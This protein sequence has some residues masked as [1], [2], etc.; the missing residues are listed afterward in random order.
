MIPPDRVPILRSSSR[1]STSIQ[2][3]VFLALALPLVVGCEANSTDPGRSGQDPSLAAQEAG[4][5]GD[6]RLENKLQE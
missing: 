4:T 6:P 1:L 5:L 2:P 3:F